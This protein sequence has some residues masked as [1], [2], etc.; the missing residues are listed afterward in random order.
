MALVLQHVLPK[1]CRRARDYGFLHGNVKRRLKIAQWVLRVLI[2]APK[3]SIA[4]RLSVSD[5][6]SSA[7]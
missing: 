2:E 7:Q 3:K 6:V 1:G 5:R 4:R